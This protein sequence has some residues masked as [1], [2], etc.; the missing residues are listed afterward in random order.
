[1]Y[2]QLFYSFQVDLNEAKFWSLIYKHMNT[3]MWKK[4]HFLL[5]SHLLESFYIRVLFS[6]Q[7]LLFKTY[8]AMWAPWFSSSS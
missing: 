7:Q 8:N 3:A 5:K 1:M 2:T 4:K 6:K